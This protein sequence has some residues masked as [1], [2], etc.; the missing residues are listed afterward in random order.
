M[1][2]KE[3][4][5]RRRRA[6]GPIGSVA[7]R[8]AVAENRALAPQA[9]PTTQ[10]RSS[11]DSKPSCAGRDSVDSAERGSLARP[12]GEIPASL[13]LLAAAR[14]LGGAGRVVEHLA[15]VSERVKPA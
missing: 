2:D 15:D 3:N 6:D 13:N 9:A 4:Q 10:G 8:S 7:D 1:R 14:L 11:L 5:Q 12:A